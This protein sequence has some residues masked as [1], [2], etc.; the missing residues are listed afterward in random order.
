MYICE[1][2]LMMH[3]FHFLGNYYSQNLSFRQNNSGD[4][5]ADSSH[6]G[7]I[8]YGPNGNFPFMTSLRVRTV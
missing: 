1:R 2:R 3:K 6:C 8:M 7:K 4:L 5:I